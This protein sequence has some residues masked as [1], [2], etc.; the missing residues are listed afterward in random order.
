MKF[1]GRPKAN[2]PDSRMRVLWVTN[3]AAPYR[4]PVWEHLRTNHKLTVGL[5][6]TRESLAADSRANRGADWQAERTGATTFVE[7]PTWKIKAGEARY[8]VFKGILPIAAVGNQD[9]VVFG[10]WESPAYWLLLLAAMASGLGRVG[11]YES[12]LATMKHRTGPIAWIRSCFFRHM[13]AMVVPGPA[14]REALLHIG[15]PRSKILDGFNAIDVEKFHRQSSSVE[16]FEESSSGH[17]YLYVGQLIPRKRVEAIIEAFSRT[18]EPSDE[19]TIVGS[20]HLK[21]DLTIQAGKL[22]PSVHFLPYIA[23]EFLPQLMAKHH[24]LVLASSE[25]VWGMVVNEALAAGLHV[26]VAEDCGVVPSVASMRGVFVANRHLDDLA[27]RMQESRDSWGGRI[28]KPEILQWT[29]ERFG[30]VFSG[31]IRQAAL[32]SR[33]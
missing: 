20:G 23:N 28:A 29:P 3:F 19:L 14:A 22:G 13:H 31:A 16:P 9:V 7:L 26:V 32:A 30:D 10:G 21:D 6:E 17:R 27:N 18:A 5:L 1:Q 11:F 33:G 2:N 12:T 24:T 8:Y 25:E 15:V 4:I